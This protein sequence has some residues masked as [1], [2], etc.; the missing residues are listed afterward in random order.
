MNTHSEPVA[1]RNSVTRRVV[2]A[3]LQDHVVGRG[4]RVHLEQGRHGG[5]LVRTSPDARRISP[6]TRDLRFATVLRRR[7][8]V[9]CGLGVHSAG[10]GAVPR[11]STPIDPVRTGRRLMRRRWLL[12]LQMLRQNIVAASLSSPVTRLFLDQ[13]DPSP[14]SSHLSR[15]GDVQI[16]ARNVQH[17]VGLQDPTQGAIAS[18][19]SGA[20]IR[21]ARL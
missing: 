13:K 18:C 19:C 11:Q 16:S 2:V 21:H 7:T 12:P 4:Q 3:L 5:G 1:R 10:R 8:C 14:T 6:T 17:A 15:V 9:P 20:G